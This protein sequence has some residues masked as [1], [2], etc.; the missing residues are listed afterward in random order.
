MTWR[1]RLVVL[2]VA[3]AV[4]GL[5]GSAAWAGAAGGPQDH[6]RQTTDQILAIVKDPALKAPDKKEARR[7]KI[8]QAVDRRFNWEVMA[9][10]ALG[11]H[12][13]RRTP[14]ERQVFVPLFVKLV[15]N[16]YMARI[17]GYSGDK[18]LY[19]GERIDGAYGSA[20]VEIVN[21][22]GTAIPVVYRMQKI[23]EQWL[24]YDVTIEGVRLVLNYRTQ[25]ASMLDRMSFKAFIEK[26]EAKVA[27][28]EEGEE[29]EKE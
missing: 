22:K 6:I 17:E 21:A 1:S 28:M 14:E 16:T 11:G 12:W 8:Q 5:A 18:V 25:F 27:K 2:V 20:S 9:R 13:R 10:G 29:S 4:L 15:R 19:K 23:G 3:C 7:E 24:V 26:L